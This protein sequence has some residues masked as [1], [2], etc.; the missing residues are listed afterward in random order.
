M[1]PDSHTSFVWNR[2]DEA[3]GNSFVHRRALKDT[4]G[5]S[6]WR[7]AT[8][9]PLAGV[10][11]GCRRTTHRANPVGKSFVTKNIFSGRPNIRTTSSCWRIPAEI[12]YQMSEL[13][14]R[15]RLVIIVRKGI[16]P[17]RRRKKEL[18]GDNK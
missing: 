2:W 6:N 12:N 15:H 9:Q 8:A 11:N 4:K 18:L 13:G 16:S 17:C 5:W 14:H 10:G 1:K 3:G 7:R